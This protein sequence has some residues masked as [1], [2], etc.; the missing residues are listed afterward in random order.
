MD[1]TTQPVGIAPKKARERGV[2]WLRRVRGPGRPYLSWIALVCSALLTWLAWSVSARSLETRLRSQLHQRS[3]QIAADL[4]QRIAEHETVLRSSAALFLA[5]DHVTRGEFHDY[6]RALE[7]S[8]HFPGILGIG[9][10]QLVRGDEV[11]GLEA[12]I[13]AEGYT[14]FTVR[15]GGTPSWLTPIVMIEPF[16]GRN[17]RAFGYDMFSEQRRRAAIERAWHTGQPSVTPVV[18]LIQDTPNDTQPGLLLYFPVIRSVETT[19]FAHSTRPLGFV[20]SPLRT[21]DLVTST[22]GKGPD[23]LDFA[24]YDDG[25]VSPFYDTRRGKPL[26]AELTRERALELPGRVWRARFW[27]RPNFES[28]ISR[29]EP[30]LV[31]CAGVVIN[32]LLFWALSVSATLRTRAQAMAEQMTQELKLAHGREQ[33]QMLASLR[34]KETLLKEIH[35][36]VKNNLQV[37]SSLL[38][39]QRSHVQDERALEPLRQSQSRVLAMAALHEFLYRSEKLSHVDMRAYLTHLISTLS[40]SYPSAAHV[41]V[42]LELDDVPLDVDHAIPCGLITNELVS[43]AFKYAFAQRGG[44]LIVSFKRESEAVLIVEDDGPGLRT[45]QQSEPPRTLGL[46]LVQLL[47]QQLDGRLTVEA[48]PGARFRLRFPFPER[49]E[50]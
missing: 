8:Q 12:R 4:L 35:H 48:A 30:T 36:R 22:V 6:C 38:S 45:P 25:D 18:R 50:T 42:I 29:A 5:S 16:A 1:L 46:Q 10:A 27:T 23:D 31:L 13:R 33:S 20:Y 41:N 40:E 24:L 34:E 47:T 14:S 39:L 21:H 9:F 17:L 3:E 15:P 7:L 49:A 11:P 26:R 43:N 44:R 19:P 32:A 2:R 37:V 28:S